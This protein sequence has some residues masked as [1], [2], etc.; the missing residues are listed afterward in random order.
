MV[1]I[2][3][4]ITNISI[5]LIIIIFCF[6]LF[7]STDIF[8]IKKV[9][10]FLNFIQNNHSSKLIQ[11]IIAVNPN[12]NCPDN[13]SP[14]QFYNYPGTSKGCL[15]SGNKLE[16]DSC[17]LITKL[18]KKT[19]E[20]KETK[21]KSFNNIFSK[22]LCAIPFNEENYLSNLNNINKNNENKKFCGLLDTTGRKYYIDI[23]K[24]CPINKIKINNEKT[25]NDEEYIFNSIELIKDKYYLHYSNNYNEN[26]NH[27]NYILTNNSLFISEGLPCI[28][29][30]EINTFHIQYKLSKAKNYYICNTH[31][32]KKRLDTRYSLIEKVQK[33]ELYK[34]NDIYLD[35]FYDYPFQDSDL[36]LYQIGYIG[37]DYNFNIEIE[38]NINNL[39][40]DINRIYDLNKVNQFIKKIIYSFIFIIIV[41]LILKYF[42]SDR[43][44]YIW[45]SILLA[46]IMINLIINIIIN[47]LTKNFKKLKNINSVNNDEIFN[48]QIKYIN[49]LINSSINKNIK[50]IIGDILIGI[51]VGIFNILNYFY[52]NNPK[53]NILKFKNRTDYCQN[54]KFYNS[55]NVLKPTSFDIK[56][57]NLI[58]SKEEIELPRINNEKSEENIIDDSNDEEENNLTSAKNDNYDT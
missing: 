21:E 19:K 5:F 39:I 11:S 51:C 2:L 8:Q 36:G 13:S 54:K 37:T 49:S 28:N 29:P 31:I 52:F 9:V 18:F 33:N 22:K 17:N 25:I 6:I 7:S 43:T 16:K 3:F 48:L 32:D 10:P 42:I 27:N 14:F 24:E 50:I 1:N 40:S 41:S 58:K 34:D 55:I 47:I 35:N 57:E 26:N 44:I 4:T 53:N 56:K 46:I 30:E 23:D 15:I 20:I 38:P 45:N 12:D